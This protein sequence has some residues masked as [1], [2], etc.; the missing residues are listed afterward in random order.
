MPRRQKI[1]VMGFDKFFKSIEY[2]T[3]DKTGYWDRLRKP[4]LLKIRRR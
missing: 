4:Q 3:Y 1:K 2:R